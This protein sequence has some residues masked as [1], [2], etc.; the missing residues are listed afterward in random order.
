M[1]WLQSPESQSKAWQHHD[2]TLEDFGFTVTTSKG[3]AVGISF[4]ENDP[5]RD[6]PRKSL[7]AAVEKQIATELSLSATNQ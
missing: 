5:I 7:V 3:K 2:V 1:L 4:W 6:L